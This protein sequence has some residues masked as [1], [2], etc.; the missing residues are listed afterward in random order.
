MQVKLFRLVGAEHH[1]TLDLSNVE[2]IGSDR[3]VAFAT[4]RRCVE[5]FA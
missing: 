3:D 1:V 4:Q 5:I 2:A